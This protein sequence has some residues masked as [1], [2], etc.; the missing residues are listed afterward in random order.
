[1]VADFDLDYGFAFDGDGDR[2]IAVDKNQKIYDGDMLLFVIANYLNQRNLLN[3]ST[4]VL[5][6]MSNLGIIK[7][8]ERQKIEVRLADV[9]DKFVLETLENED[10]TLGGEN[11]GHIIN[12]SLLNT[13]DG[14]LNA[15]YLI[16]I[17]HETHQTLAELCQ[18][19]VFYP[20]KLVNLKDV[21]KQLV[22]HPEVVQ[23][24]E[25]MKNLL[26]NDGKI[27]VRPSGTEPLIRV[28]V[29]AKSEELLTFC[30]NKIV[31]TIL[32]L[33]RLKKTT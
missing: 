33:N 11:S 28:S 14:V 23:V 19:I 29:S 22:F 15:A 9:G 2:L 26:G 4:V 8:F 3:K 31:E 10:L 18:D 32:R 17:L 27:L 6:K 13:G 25:D 24:V 7:A 20:D 5:T 21:D 30:Q 1:V 12:R 16:K